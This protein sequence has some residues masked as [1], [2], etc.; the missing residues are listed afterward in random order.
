[1][2]KAGADVPIRQAVQ[3]DGT[4][5]WALEIADDVKFDTSSL[6]QPERNL[7]TKAI[8]DLSTRTTPKTALVEANLETWFV[9]A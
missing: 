5:C 3:K 7:H 8:L 6:T 2:A 1:M 4:F 9:Q